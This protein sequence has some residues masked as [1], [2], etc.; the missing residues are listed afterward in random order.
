MRRFWKIALSSVLI[1]TTSCNG[2]V[3]AGI[4]KTASTDLSNYISMQTNVDSSSWDL[5]LA[6]YKSMSTSYQN[7]RAVQ[8]LL[9]STLAGKCG[10]NFLTFLTALQTGTPGTGAGNK[11]LFLYLMN[12]FSSTTVNMQVSSSV[13]PVSATL[14]TD[15][16]CSWAENVMYNLQ[17]TYGVANLTTDE[18][19]FFSV[20]SLAKIGLILK[21]WM[22]RNGT[23]S[24]TTTV[25][26][27]NNSAIDNSTGIPTFY[28]NQIVSGF[29]NFN[30]YSAS[31]P[32]LGSSF[33]TVATLCTTITG[34]G[35]T[36]CTD[37]DP[38][39]VS[40][41]DEKLMRS[42]LT[43]NDT[44]TYAGLGL[45][46]FTSAVPSAA[47]DPGSNLWQCSNAVFALCCP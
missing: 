38:T 42:I 5:A 19:I 37:Y 39:T 30:R 2:N 13:A 17:Q 26:I 27:C 3:I 24:P 21:Y 29:A 43:V 7:Q 8:N 20:Y 34:A 12:A 44:G 16:Y 15:T 41:T 22:D 46:S 28:M 25:D 18:K 31:I 45:N 33:G 6:N 9:A 36:I 47:T 10:F 11:P 32:S 35:G 23:G 1:L 40:T 14:V 4:A